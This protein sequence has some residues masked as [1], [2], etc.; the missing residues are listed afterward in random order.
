[1]STAAWV[2]FAL[3]TGYVWGGFL[4]LLALAFRKERGKAEE[5]E[6]GRGLWVP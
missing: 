4:L 1:V 5:G 2:T 3:V 6:A